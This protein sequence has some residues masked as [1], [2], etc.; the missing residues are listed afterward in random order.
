MLKTRVPI[1]QQ[2]DQKIE[3]GKK[4]VNEKTESVTKQVKN[5]DVYQK[6]QSNTE[7]YKNTL[8]MP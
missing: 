8:K 1:E 4:F 5:S 6:L 7:D 3:E 2:I